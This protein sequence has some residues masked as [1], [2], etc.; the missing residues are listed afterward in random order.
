M[1]KETTN[2]GVDGDELRGFLTL[3]GAEVYVPDGRFRPLNEKKVKEIAESISKLGQM[4]PILVDEMGNLI[5]GNHRLHACIELGIPVEAKVTKE[6]NP[7]ILAL[8]EI[9]ENL[10]RKELSP[11]EL[12][13]HLA[14]RKALYNK[15]YPDTAKRGAKSKTEGS[16]QKNFADDTAETIGKS[17]KS[18]NR[19]VNRGEKSSEELNKAREDKVITT[20]EADAIIKEAGDDVEKQKEAIKEMIAKKAEKKNAELEAKNVPVEASE[21]EQVEDTEGEQVEDL[22]ATVKELRDKIYK[23]E[24]AKQDAEEEFN[25]KL[26]KLEASNK[27]YKERIAKAKEKYPDIKV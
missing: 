13:A 2:V 12:E 3:D 4:Q 22:T 16:G 24:M 5:F 14:E 17:A 19:M 18:V 10:N 21:G 20:G 26:E 8:M 15:L 25:V 1:G 7:D 11:I 9:D 23:L 27:R 6:K